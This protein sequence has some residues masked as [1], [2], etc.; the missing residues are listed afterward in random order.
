MTPDEADIVRQLTQDLYACRSEIKRLNARVSE[1]KG[2]LSYRLMAPIRLFKR[3]FHSVRKRLIN[4]AFASRKLKSLREDYSAW[5][6]LYDQLGPA[7]IALIR[8]RISE[9]PMQP[10]V[11]I[12]IVATSDIKPSYID[13]SYKSIVAQLYSNVEIFVCLP[14]TT[15]VPQDIYTGAQAKIL[16][17]KS[18]QELWATLHM[19]IAVARGEFTAVVGAGTALAIDAIARALHRAISNRDVA[20]IYSDHDELDCSGGRTNPFFKPTWDP[21]LMLTGNFLGPFILYRSDLLRKII[22]DDDFQ[23]GA[24]REYETLTRWQWN[25]A[26]QLTTGVSRT[27]ILRLPYV[28][29]HCS[30]GLAHPELGD[31]SALPIIRNELARRGCGTNMEL[32]SVWDLSLSEPSPRV[33]IIIATRDKSD[34]LRKCLAGILHRT[35]YSSFDIIIVDN[36]SCEPITRQYFD[37]LRHNDRVKIIP[38]SGPFNFSAINNI[39]V[40]RSDGEIIAFLNNDIDVITPRWLAEMVNYAVRADVGVVGAKLYYPNDTIQH[41]GMILGMHGGAGHIFRGLHRLDPGPFGLAVRTQELSAVTGACMVMRRSVYNEVGG[42]DEAFPV[43]FNDVDLC[44]R[45]RERGLRVIWTPH[46]ELYHTEKATRGTAVQHIT[47][48]D[49]FRNRW[50][51]RLPADPSFNPNLSLDRPDRALSFPPRVRRR[52]GMQHDACVG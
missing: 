50:S 47:G 42:M 10:L 36:E 6:S 18:T 27:Q 38:F 22:K 9:W 4:R 33:S 12:V 30:A 34:L 8:Q 44:L 35:E 39:A 2:T 32:H 7:D 1:L 40:E 17:V 43:D 28:L 19:T 3:L 24:T 21:E 51:D 52:N 20:A 29:S 48:L 45:V 37:E 49:R 14:H 31:A 41:A 15:S 23:P 25:M 16:R 46:A 26:I 11:T 5:I 13:M